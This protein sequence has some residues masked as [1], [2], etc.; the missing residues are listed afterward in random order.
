MRDH[1]ILHKGISLKFCI[2]LCLTCDVHCLKEALIILL[3]ELN[4][5]HN[6]HLCPKV[7]DT[8]ATLYVSLSASHREHA[9]QK[10]IPIYHFWFFKLF[11]LTL[12]LNISPCGFESRSLT[13][14]NLII[15]ALDNCQRSGG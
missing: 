13:N 5:N 15:K 14:S 12:N 2:T 8:E 7:S 11:N 3:T 9:R 1:N 10:T 6:K 4:R